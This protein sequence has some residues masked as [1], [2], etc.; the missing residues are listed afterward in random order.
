[1]FPNVRA[2]LR[3]QSTQSKARESLTLHPCTRAKGSYDQRRLVEIFGIECMGSLCSEPL[4]CLQALQQ[5][6]GLV[7]EA[8]LFQNIPNALLE[9]IILHLWPGSLLARFQPVLSCKLNELVLFLLNFGWGRS[10]CLGNG[11]W[12]RCL[13]SFGGTG[14]GAFEALRV[15]HCLAV[16]AS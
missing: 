8:V 14:A 1:M 4:H 5:E 3:W 15:R 7:L 12:L 2:V 16:V 11:G 6:K 13:A 9:D 10:L